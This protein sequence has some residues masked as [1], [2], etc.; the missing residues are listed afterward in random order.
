MGQNAANMK[1]C[2]V[3]RTTAALSIAASG[4]PQVIPFEAAIGGGNTPFALWEGTTNPSRITV[5]RAGY[6]LAVACVEFAANATGDRSVGFRKNGVASLIGG[7]TIKSATLA[8]EL[9]TSALIFLVAGDYLEVWVNQTSGG[10]L[11]VT[12]TAAK[13]SP[14]FS[15]F[16]QRAGSS[17]DYSAAAQTGFPL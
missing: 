17:T 10:A 9:Q 2:Q 13:Q 11:N 3:T 5:N 8:N 1:F 15:L 7:Q 14:S 16:M 12:T 6:F 4:T